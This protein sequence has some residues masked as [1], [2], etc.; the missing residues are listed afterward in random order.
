M[1]IQEIKSIFQSKIEQFWKFVDAP[2]DYKDTSYVEKK[3]TSAGI[4]DYRKLI[5]ENRLIN[6]E[7]V[8]DVVTGAI[9]GFAVVVPM[10][11][12]SPVSGAVIGVV[13]MGIIWLKKLL[14]EF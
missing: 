8:K 4:F 5:L 13:V 12:F 3:E 7:F 9:I 6:S 2:V 10:P 11:L 14:K 1:N